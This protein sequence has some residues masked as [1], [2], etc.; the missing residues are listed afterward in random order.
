MS[1]ESNEIDRSMIRGGPP[2][3]G[4]AGLSP[5]ETLK[6]D[7]LPGN[8]GPA[9]PAQSPPATAVFLQPAKVKQGSRV[10]GLVFFRKPKGSKLQI[11]PADMLD[12]ID[13]PVNGVVF[14]F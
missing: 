7:N 1:A 6:G 5:S 8:L 13:I 3:G 14:R 12:E 2:Q 11:T 9:S 10:A 4:A